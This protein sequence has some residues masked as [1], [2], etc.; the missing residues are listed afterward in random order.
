MYVAIS[1]ECVV[2]K[3]LNSLTNKYMYDYNNSYTN[4]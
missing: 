2:N 1:A 4:M 3:I